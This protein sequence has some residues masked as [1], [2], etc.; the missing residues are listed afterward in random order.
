MISSAE[1]L[2][3]EKERLTR[4]PESIFEEEFERQQ[5]NIINIIIGNFDIQMREIRY[6]IT[7][8]SDLRQSLKIAED[9]L[10]VK[11]KDLKSENEKLK[12]IMKGLYEYQIVP[13]FVE[14]KLVDL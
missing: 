5:Q 11:V 8:L 13:E 1:N 4:L 14:N 12:T 10:E 9:T 2:K 6:L 3:F 7:K